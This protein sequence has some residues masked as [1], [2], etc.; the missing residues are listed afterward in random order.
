M[1][2][3]FIQ[4][5]REAIPNIPPMQQEIIIRYITKHKN[6][7]ILFDLFLKNQTVQYNCFLFTYSS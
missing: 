5:G 4:R 1:S 3:G 7:E 6:P 2:P